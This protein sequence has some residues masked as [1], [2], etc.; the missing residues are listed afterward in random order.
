MYREDFVE[1]NFQGRYFNGLQET[2][3][4]FA[5]PQI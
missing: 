2:L 1:D 4:F 3:Q 5:L